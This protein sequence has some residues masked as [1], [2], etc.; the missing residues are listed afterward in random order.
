MENQNL[1][2]EYSEIISSTIGKHERR[3]RA[4]LISLSHF[5]QVTF[6]PT[7]KGPHMNGRPHSKGF[8]VD[9]QKSQNCLEPHHDLTCKQVLQQFIGEKYYS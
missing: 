4:S 1:L 6:Q 3:F 7:R 5:L 9:R 8:S 2:G